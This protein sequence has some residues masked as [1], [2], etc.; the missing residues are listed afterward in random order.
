[1]SDLTLMMIIVH[2]FLLAGVAVPAWAIWSDYRFRHAHK[3][4]AE[5]TTQH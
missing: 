1:M 3:R 5:R 2:A 4:D